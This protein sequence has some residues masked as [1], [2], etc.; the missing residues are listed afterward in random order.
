MSLGDATTYLADF[1]SLTYNPSLVPLGSQQ[2]RP[3]EN[4]KSLLVSTFDRGVLSAV[5]TLCDIAAVFRKQGQYGPASWQKKS[6][7]KPISA[8]KLTSDEKLEKAL[9]IIPSSRPVGPTNLINGPDNAKSHTPKKLKLSA[10]DPNK[11]RYHW[12]PVTPQS[13]R[14]SSSPNKSFKNAS[15]ET[16]HRE[17]SS[18]PLKRSITT[19]PVNLPNKPPKRR[20]LV[21]MEWKSRGDQKGN[22]KY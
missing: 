11:G 15:M 20:K 7:Q 19:P 4:D 16:K 13:I 9:F 2:P 1:Q 22:G 10:N 6:S 5:Q 8:S 14:S 17:S 18:S 12:S 3:T 21:P